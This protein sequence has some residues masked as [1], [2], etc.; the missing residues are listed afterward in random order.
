MARGSTFSL[1]VPVL[2]SIYHGLRQISSS[3]TP[4]GE[5]NAK[6]FTAI[7]ARKL[8]R[9]VDPLQLSSLAMSDKEER[10]MIVESYSPHRF[11]Q[12]FN[13]YQDIPGKLVEEAC[14]LNLPDVVGL[15]QSCTKLGTKAKLRIPGKGEVT[16]IV[17]AHEVEGT[18]ATASKAKP[19]RAKPAVLP[20]VSN[21][22]VDGTNATLG[23]AKAGKARPSR[24]K[25]KVPL[26]VSTH[27]VDGANATSRKAKASKDRPSKAK[28]NQG[29]DLPKDASKEMKRST[30][31]P[32]PLLKISAPKIPSVIV[33]NPTTEN[34]DKKRSLVIC[35]GDSN[36]SQGD[37]HWNRPKKQKNIAQVT[38]LEDIHIDTDGFFQDVPNSSTPL[39]DLEAHLGVNN[40]NLGDELYFQSSGGS[41]DGPDSFGLLS[42]K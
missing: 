12:Q 7:G 23:K 41:I 28:P 14:P 15:W 13:F 40:L 26:V 10:L 31:K 30:F 17:N 27:E 3:P 6:H 2:A 22:E 37:R 1:A 42:R 39:E 29:K 25:S 36:S 24:A 33:K 11:S 5:K 20:T 9:S 21:E 16:P 19:S 8:L 38:P 35:D 34:R 32:K 18:N 4:T